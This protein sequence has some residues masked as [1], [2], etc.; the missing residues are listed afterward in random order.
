[1]SSGVGPSATLRVLLGPRD[2]ENCSFVENLGAIDREADGGTKRNKDSPPG[3]PPGEGVVHSPSPEEQLMGG[4]SSC[5]PG[6]D[7]TNRLSLFLCS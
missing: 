4:G 6:Q 7:V 1:M 2:R 3:P 5:L